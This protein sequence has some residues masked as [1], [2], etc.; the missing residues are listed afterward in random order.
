[1]RLKVADFV[2]FAI[3][4]QVVK[5]RAIVSELVIDVVNT[6]EYFLYRFYLFAN[7]QLA[8]DLVANVVTC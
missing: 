4:E 6:T 3:G 1:M 8:T 5:L 7:R 2:R